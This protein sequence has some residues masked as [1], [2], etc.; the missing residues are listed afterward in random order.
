MKLV[1]LDITNKLDKMRLISF[2]R[3]FFSTFDVIRFIFR[4]LLYN[5]NKEIRVFSLFFYD[6]MFN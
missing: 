6:T 5:G 4:V 2:K 1:W 3:V